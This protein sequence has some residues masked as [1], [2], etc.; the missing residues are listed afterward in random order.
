MKMRCH[1]TGELMT[2]EELIEIAVEQEIIYMDTD[3]LIFEPNL[4]NLNIMY[5]V[6]QDENKRKFQIT[7]CEGERW[8]LS[9][10]DQTEFKCLGLFENP[11]EALEYCRGM[12]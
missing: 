1:H 5:I 11:E 6:D 7:F 9:T 3:D 12:F 10:Y 2:I 8:V 4:Y